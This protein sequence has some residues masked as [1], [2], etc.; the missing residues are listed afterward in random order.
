MALPDVAT[1]R[2]RFCFGKGLV[3]GVEICLWL[4]SQRHR[5]LT[6]AREN[7]LVNKSARFS[8]GKSPPGPTRT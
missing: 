4:A 6:C 3:W 2:P 8:E 7:P 1:L 5:E